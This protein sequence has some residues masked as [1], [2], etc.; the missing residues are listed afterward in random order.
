VQEQSKR[1]GDNTWYVDSGCS[2]HMT[3]NISLLSD[4]KSIDGG[5]VVFAGDK[6]GRITGEGTISNDSVSFDRVNYCEQLKHNLLSVS[7]VCD[8]KY[9]TIFND[10]ECMI[11]KKGFKVPEEWIL[12]RAPRRNDIYSINMDT[13]KSTEE[14]SCLLS[15]ASE[16]DSV[17]WHRRMGHINFRRMNYLVKHELVTGF[18]IK[19][20]R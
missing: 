14:Y 2:R 12:L 13:L 16:K 15:K 1:S 8:K 5:N 10:S 9:T 18:Q 6:G 3:G 17:M 19:V 11:L 4:V 20:S 7:Q